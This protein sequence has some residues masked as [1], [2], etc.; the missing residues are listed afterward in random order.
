MQRLGRPPVPAS[1][2]WRRR[3]VRRARSPTTSTTSRRATPRA[4]RRTPSR[5]RR[6]PCAGAA[7]STRSRAWRASTP[8]SSAGSATGS[9]STSPPTTVRRAPRAPPRPAAVEVR[10][11]W[12]PL[13]DD[14]GLGR[15]V[16]IQPWEFGSIPRDWV[17]PLQGVDEVW[18]PSAFVRDMYVG[19]GVPADRV[20]VVP[21]GVDLDVY[22]PDGPAPSAGRR[23]RL[24]VPVRRRHDLPQGHRRAA[25]GVRGGVRRP[26]RRA[27]RGQGRR[28]RHVL[29][30]HERRRRA[31]PPRRPPARTIARARPTTSTTRGSRRCTAAATCSCTRTAARASRCRCWRRWPAAGRCS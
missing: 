30:R 31:A 3:S 13:F 2:R 5:R 28:R 19:D 6:W 18:V 12:P 23:R 8:R 15:L 20:H 11:Q 22:R 29:Q 10:H 24:R 26:R 1:T 17:E 9:P 4:R 21:N 7:T 25:G 27:A 14:P 16:L